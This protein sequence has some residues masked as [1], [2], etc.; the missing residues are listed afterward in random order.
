MKFLNYDKIEWVSS[1]EQD[2][3][4]MIRREIFIEIYILI[5]TN[6][7]IKFKMKILS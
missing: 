5:D 1:Q 4:L 3:N 2:R 6:K 7:E